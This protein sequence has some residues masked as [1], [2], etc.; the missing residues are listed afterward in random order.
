MRRLMILTI[1]FVMGCALGLWLFT[2]SWLLFITIVAIIAWGLLCFI[3]TN[4]TRKIIS[5]LC[6]GVSIG[7]CWTWG[8]NALY[9]DRARQWDGIECD[10]TIELTDYPLD[11]IYGSTGNGEIDIDGVSYKVNYY[12][13]QE[14][15]LK[16]GDTLSGNFSFRFTGYGDRDE[17]TYHQGNGVF[18]VA[19]A[20][21]RVESHE[22]SEIP[23]KY[24]PA[25]WRNEI[26][27][28]IDEIFPDDV[29]GFSKSLL[30]G[31]TGDLS[32]EDN[33][34]LKIS[35]I[36]H[37]AAVSG[38]HIS[39]LMSFVFVFTRGRRFLHAIIAIP[40]LLLF[41][42]LAGFTPS[43]VRACIMQIIFLVAIVV[44]REYDPPTALSI[45]VLILVTINPAVLNSVSFQLSVGCVIGILLFS[46]KIYD[47]LSKTKI[48]H[49]KGKSLVAKIKRAA[50]S[51]TSITLGT[52]AT[53]LP[54]SAYYFGNISIVSV[55]TNFL[56]LWII[57][58][59][60]YG[61]GI[62]CL[63]SF[64]YQPFGSAIAWV[65]SWLI[66]FV[67]TVAKFLSDIPFASVS[68][69]NLY[70]LIWVI[71]I[72]VLFAIFLLCKKKKPFL[73]V[74]L[75][76]CSLFV[77][78]VCAYVEPRMDNYRLTVLDVDQGQC[79]LLQSKDDCYVIDCGGF[80]NVCAADLA[81]QTLRSNG[82]NH[83]DGLILTH[84]DYDHAGYAQ[85]LV[86]QIETDRIFIPT[87]DMGNTIRKNIVHEY[88]EIVHRVRYT[89][90][91]DCGAGKLT[92]YPGKL[93]KDG[94]ESSLCILFQVDECDILITG[95]RNTVGEQYLIDNEE[96]PM[97]DILVVGHHGSDSSSSLYLLQEVRPKNA[98]ISVG[99]DNK[100]GHPNQTVINRLK[101]FGCII[102]RTD[103]DGTIVFRG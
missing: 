98:V 15:N 13:N 43:V 44:N 24:Y 92:I 66:R 9:V 85:S 82:I 69:N 87:S 40:L 51:S 62:S 26:V 64:I 76:A 8:Y 73:F 100:Y 2:S 90:E 23:L 67:L 36:R 29:Q 20:N 34:A 31:E 46:G 30:I 79:I 45:A 91:M 65:V 3:H 59:C 6:L 4:S 32:D 83:I 1:G 11:N 18:L 17:S 86:S 61:I 7:S 74:L 60:F 5:I 42:S 81:A 55:L 33:A 16:P 47:R 80:A 70:F 68:I 41:T 99:K 75:T 10:V 93:G 95:D 78:M 49:S 28:K 39:I 53:T 71:F 101:R 48:G 12:L 84:F 96:L 103:E 77:S 97:V 63:L 19:Y 52:M 21:G 50:I 22:N 25:Y 27:N 37:V 54:I 58:F 38:L 72:Y 56:T 57:S 35:G 102:W 94:N 88:G 14:A 89:N